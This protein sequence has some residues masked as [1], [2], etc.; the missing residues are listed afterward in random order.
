[1]TRSRT[2][3]RGEK[4]AAAIE[5]ALLAPLLFVIVFAIIGFGIA[6]MQLQSIRGA[7]REGARASAVGATTAQVQSKVLASGI[8]SLPAG[9]TLNLTKATCSG[10]VGSD[11]TV[12][13]NWNGNGIDV[14]I[15]FLPNITLH[16]N[17]SS[18]FQC[19]V[20]TP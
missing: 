7:V 5:M 8:G 4:G 19:E 18:T 20:R 12:A 15:P 1:M 2:N 13:L 3:L 9:T 16:P 14:P 11:T 10:G 17:V 6:F